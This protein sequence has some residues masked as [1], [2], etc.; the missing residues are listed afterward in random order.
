MAWFHPHMAMDPRLSMFQSAPMAM[1]ATPGGLVPVSLA[2][3]G[4]GGMMAMPM[5]GGMMMAAPM[6]GG[7]MVAARRG[8]MFACRQCRQ[9]MQRQNGPLVTCD[10][11]GCATRTATS[12]RACNRDFCDDCCVPGGAASS[13]VPRAAVGD[14]SERLAQG[15]TRTLYHQTDRDAAKSIIDSQKMRRGSVG[16]VGGGIYFA[17]SVEDTERKATQKGVVLQATVRLGRTKTLASRDSSITFTSLCG[18][19]Y[20]SVRLTVFNGDEYVV[21]NYDQVSDI[22]VVRG[23]V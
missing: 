3:P 20:D 13:R 19:G 2:G 14:R 11:C 17:L 8:A 10:D 5:G 23:N 6:G 22:R 1:M 12:C 15:P 9:P 4:M 21:Y 7:M 18:E 16:S